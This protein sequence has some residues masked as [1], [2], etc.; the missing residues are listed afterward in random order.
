MKL[1]GGGGKNSSPFLGVRGHPGFNLELFH[2]RYI[3]LPLYSVDCW[4]VVSPLNSL[5]LAQTPRVPE[6][7][8]HT[9]GGK[10]MSRSQR[11]QFLREV[12]SG[13]FAATL[14]AT[15]FD[16]GL[17]ATHA[18]EA[19]AR[20]KFGDQEELVS[21]F[22]HTPSSKIFEVVK[23]RLKRGDSIG[24]LVGAS[25]LANVRTFG[26]EDYVGYHT[27][28]ALSPALMMAKENTGSQAVLPV[29]K[30]LYRNARHIEQNGGGKRETLKEISPD[31]A[32]KLDSHAIRKACKASDMNAAEQA[33]ASAKNADPRTALDAILDV[34]EDAAEVHRVVLAFRA[35]DL[36]NLVGKEHAHALLRQSLHYCVKN[37]YSKYSE[38]SR[39]IAA[40]LPKLLDECK[41]PRHFPTVRKPETKWVESF[42]RTIFASTPERAA[43][44][45]AFALADGIEPDS[46]GEAISLAA[47]ELVLRDEG[48][49][50]AQTSDN[51]PVGSVHGD[52]IGVH[53]SD[54]AHA[55]RN[56]SRVAGPK[57]QCSA[58]IVGAFQVALDRT[59]RG[60]DFL[61]WRPYP[62]A[63]DLEK[64]PQS[65]DPARLLDMLGSAIRNKDQRFAAS[66]SKRLEGFSEATDKT[67]GILRQYSTLQ[68][69]ALHAEKFYATARDHFLN[70]R[71]ELRW[72]YVVSLARVV[73]SGYGYE[74]PGLEDA[75]T[76]LT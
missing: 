30:V 60:G 54:S 46:I 26:G 10:S 20:L 27:L 58:L 5:F 37:E 73:A 23:A 75:R 38:R 69:G 16:L 41:L 40:V 33:F 17:T 66:V 51:K 4:R 22:Q 47:H 48:R 42:A 52:S 68:D 6:A 70:G 67:F 63:E 65:S 59:A 32:A 19:P 34:V 13:M 35:W 49:P 7:F 50:K 2:F 62:H 28:M 3:S 1:R 36:M 9:E 14:G 18:D 72:S 76:I 29:L 8:C 57:H 56:L 11:R 55:W 44:A 21:L 43:E 64:V 24:Q 74:A 31:P 15:A 61:N 71:P 45:V 25:A 39:G 53:A 12:G